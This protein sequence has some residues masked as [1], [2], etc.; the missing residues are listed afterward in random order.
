MVIGVGVHDAARPRRY[1][2]EAAFVH[3][4]EEREERAG[5]AN[6]GQVDKLLPSLELTSGDVVLEIRDDERN[7]R[8]RL[9]IADRLR[10]HPDLQHL[11]LYLT[12]TGM[13]LPLLLLVDGMR[14]PAGRMNGLMKSPTLR[15]N[16]S[17]L[18]S[19]PA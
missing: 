11:R 5:L 14:I 4:F 16:C 2:V 12:E 19:T 3:G 9:G 1:V 13:E 10:R 8:E 6:L 7:D 17:M 15:T 18:P